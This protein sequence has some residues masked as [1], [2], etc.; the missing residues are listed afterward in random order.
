MDINLVR[1]LFQNINKKLIKFV[2]LTGLFSFRFPMEEKQT[3]NEIEI[4]LFGNFLLTP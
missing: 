2:V 3:A 4:D 1:I